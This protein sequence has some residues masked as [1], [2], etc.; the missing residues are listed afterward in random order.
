MTRRVVE[1]VQVR[2]TVTGEVVA[3]EVEA[4]GHTLV[5]SPEL[6]AEL[7][8]GLGVHL[9]HVRRLRELRAETTPEAPR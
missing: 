3:V 5:M 9:A 7:E 2:W 1:Q 8:S 4:A 6:A